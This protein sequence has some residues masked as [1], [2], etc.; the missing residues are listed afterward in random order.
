MKMV[1]LTGTACNISDNPDG[2]GSSG[3]FKTPKF[4]PEVV[5]EFY[6]DN[7]KNAKV[8]FYIDSC[9][10]DKNYRQHYV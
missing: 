3:Y 2:K 9:W 4:K 5:S 10:Q 1:K 7:S 8:G 6:Y